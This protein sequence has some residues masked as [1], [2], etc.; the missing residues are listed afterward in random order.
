[1]QFGKAASYFTGGNWQHCQ[2]SQYVENISLL[3]LARV[4]AIV[5]GVV[6][7]FSFLTSVSVNLMPT[8]TVCKCYSCVL[9]FQ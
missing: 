2:D 1:M 4:T 9:Y 5:L 8:P 3:M 6:L 7:V